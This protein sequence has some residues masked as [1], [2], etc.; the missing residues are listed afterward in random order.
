[1]RLPLGEG[2]VET[3]VLAPVEQ[4][5]GVHLITPRYLGDRDLRIKTLSHN[6]ALELIGITAALPSLGTHE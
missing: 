4:R 2:R 1:M 3:R 5:I 6:L